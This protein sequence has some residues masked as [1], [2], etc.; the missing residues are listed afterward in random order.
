[1]RNDDQRHGQKGT[2]KKIFITGWNRKIANGGSAYIPW[3]INFPEVECACLAFTDTGMDPFLSS[4][5]E[6]RIWVEEP[7]NIMI[8]LS[9]RRMMREKR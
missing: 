5:K 8:N 1:M 6:C 7:A 3:N 2:K 9:I 4:W